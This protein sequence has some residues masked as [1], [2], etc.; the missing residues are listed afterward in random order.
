MPLGNPAGYADAAQAA[1]SQLQGAMAPP[2]PFQQAQ[3]QLA[4]QRMLAG[5]NFAPGGPAPAAP[6]GF[7]DMAGMQDAVTAQLRARPDVQDRVAPTLAAGQQM[8]GNLGR[9]P[10]P[11]GAPAPGPRP[12]GGFTL[13]A[14]G[15]GPG[16]QVAP[17]FQQL[18]NGMKGRPGGK[19]APVPGQGAPAAP[20]RGKGGGVPSQFRSIR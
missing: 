15:A 1:Q 10:A 7:G 3:G 8:A 13:G 19:S 6:Q 2:N 16:R 18:M 20:G 9:G 12:G 14:G 5:S 11:M 4:G 17:Q